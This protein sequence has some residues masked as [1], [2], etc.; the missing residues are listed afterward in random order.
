M[1]HQV[2][3]LQCQI[4]TFVLLGHPNHVIFSDHEKQYG[5][6]SVPSKSNENDRTAIYDMKT[7]ITLEVRITAN[8]FKGQVKNNEN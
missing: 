2:S 3:I 4:K 8:C 5:N 1:A 6:T 7:G